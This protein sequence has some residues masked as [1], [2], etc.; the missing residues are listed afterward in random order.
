MPVTMS[1]HV[2]SG[3]ERPVLYK[4]S[5]VD[6]EE[7]RKGTN[8]EIVDCEVGGASREVGGVFQVPIRRREN[9]KLRELLKAIE[10]YDR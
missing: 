7:I 2:K 9:S 10:S 1:N 4:E 5:S 8:M 3:K 6:K